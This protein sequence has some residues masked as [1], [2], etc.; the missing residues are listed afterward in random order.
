MRRHDG[1]C[2]FDLGLDEYHLVTRQL[3]VTPQLCHVGRDAADVRRHADRRDGGGVAAGAGA[4]I[5]L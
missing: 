4:V 5:G 3:L 1:V 2:L